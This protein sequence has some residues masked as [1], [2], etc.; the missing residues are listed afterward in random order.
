MASFVVLRS[1]L[2]TLLFPAFLVGTDAEAATAAPGEDQ[3]IVA[4]ASAGHCRMIVRGG[5]TVFAVW[6]TGLV[7]G[8]TF[9]ITDI[10]EDEKIEHDAT[11]DTSGNHFWISLP[12]VRGKSMGTATVGL[13]ASR[14]QMSVSYGWQM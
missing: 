2:A 10:S 6:L 1:A 7:P 11:A 14:C 12:A 5:G 3:P 8:E 4:R 13:K 9:L